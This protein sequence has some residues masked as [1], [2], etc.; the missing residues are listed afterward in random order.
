MEVRSRLGDVMGL[1]GGCVDEQ[2][3][4]WKA[5]QCGGHEVQRPRLLRKPSSVCKEGAG[6]Q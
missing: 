1:L 4:L 2:R 3:V 6:I 5:G